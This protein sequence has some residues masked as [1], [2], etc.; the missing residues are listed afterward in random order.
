[1]F[2]WNHAEETLSFSLHI[3]RRNVRS[4]FFHVLGCE[5]FAALFL[6]FYINMQNERPHT[7]MLDLSTRLKWRVATISLRY[8]VH[9]AAVM[10]ERLFWRR[11]CG[12]MGDVKS[13]LFLIFQMRCKRVGVKSNCGKWRKTKDNKSLWHT[14]C[15]DFWHQSYFDCL[16][17]QIK[18]VFTETHLFW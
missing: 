13:H 18:A 11:Q 7:C 17:L 1:M 4:I 10:A 8:D 2:F 3:F 9:Y 5:V 16:R 6:F 12:D 15:R 14:R